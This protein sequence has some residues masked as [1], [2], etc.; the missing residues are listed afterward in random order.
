MDVSG[1]VNAY[2]AF[3]AALRAVI[4]HN[5]TT[6][7]PIRSLLS[8][9]LGTAIGR[10]PVARCAQQMYA[11]FSAVVLGQPPRPMTLGQAVEVHHALLR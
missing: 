6:S 2:L 3:R 1:T 11:A 8:P 5:A 7:A 10:M 9:G 4:Q